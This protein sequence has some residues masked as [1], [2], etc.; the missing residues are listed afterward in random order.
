VPERTR[1][2]RKALRS[3][4]ARFREV[5]DWIA[6]VAGESGEDTAWGRRLA[7]AL[8]IAMTGVHRHAYDGRLDGRIDIRAEVLDD[9]I[10]VRIRDY[11]RSSGPDADVTPGPDRSFRSGGDGIALIRASVDEVRHEAVPHG[12]EIVLRKRRTETRTPAAVG[13]PDRR[14]CR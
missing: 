2:E 3:D 13:E 4:P 7:L 12:A 1:I 5:R 6:A 8:H 14:A 9:A 11:G 10:E